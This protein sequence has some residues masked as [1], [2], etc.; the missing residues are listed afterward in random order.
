MGRYWIIPPTVPAASSASFTRKPRGRAHSYQRA[1]DFELRQYLPII[2]LCVFPL[3]AEL[4]VATNV[5]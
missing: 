2:L 1:S 5:G 4:E 3:F